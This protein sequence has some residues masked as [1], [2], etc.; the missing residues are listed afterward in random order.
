VRKDTQV[1]LSGFFGVFIEPEEWRKLVHG[2]HGN[3]KEVTDNKPT[4][5]TDVVMKQPIIFP[6][7]SLC[8]TSRFAQS[9]NSP[10]GYGLICNWT[11]IK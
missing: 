6:P 1:K 11:R 2:W 5:G 3:R 7:N 8:R 10:L 4:I 9:V